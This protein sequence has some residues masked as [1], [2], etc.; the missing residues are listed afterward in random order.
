[1]R[2]GMKVANATTIKRFPM[3]LRLL[4]SLKEKGEEYVSATYLSQELGRESISIRKD[5]AVTGAEGKP[6]IG[7]SVKELIHSIEDFLGWNNT[8]DAFLI[9]VGN[10][11]SAILGYEGFKNSGLDIVAGFDCNEDKVGKIV[12]E[13]EIFHIKDL[14]KLTKR[15]HINMG[16]L[17]VPAFAAQECADLMVAAGIKAIWN[18]TPKKVSVPEGVVTQKEDMASGLAILSVKL[19]KVLEEGEL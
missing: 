8:T 7:F 15:M 5:L 14:Q 6:R 17:A 1:M 12:N 3:Y 19:S 2:K 10:L 18:F 11:G 9:G 4:K 13:R 16:I